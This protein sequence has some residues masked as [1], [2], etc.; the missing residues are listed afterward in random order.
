MEEGEGVKRIFNRSWEQYDLTYTYGGPN[1]SKSSL[2]ILDIV[3]N[4][5]LHAIK[6]NVHAINKNLNAIYKNQF[7]V[8]KSNNTI[9]LKAVYHN[10]FLANN[11]LLVV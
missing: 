10:Q 11:Q 1:N 4:K 6:K 7:T 9:N 3:I 5:N 2:L 8:N